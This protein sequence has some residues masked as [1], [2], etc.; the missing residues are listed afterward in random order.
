MDLKTA[1]RDILPTLKLKTKRRPGYEWAIDR[2]IEFH[3][4]WTCGEM[5]DERIMDLVCITQPDDFVTKLYSTYGSFCKIH[6]SLH[7]RALLPRVQPCFRCY[8][9]AVGHGM[10]SM[11]GHNLHAQM[12]PPMIAKRPWYKALKEK[13]APG[14]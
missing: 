11:C 7:I 12:P 2:P 10:C 3:E 8:R 1:L 4:C 5:V 14:S 9:W 6:E 13:D